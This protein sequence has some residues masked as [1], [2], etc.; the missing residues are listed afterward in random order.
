MALSV[1]RRAGTLRGFSLAIPLILLCRLIIAPLGY[2]SSWQTAGLPFEFYQGS[3]LPIQGIAGEKPQPAASPAYLPVP[4]RGPLSVSAPE[5][6]SRRGVPFPDVASG[7]F[8]PRPACE[9]SPPH[10]H[11]D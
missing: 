6:G 7:R 4:C 11:L 10:P 5:P 2:G 3:P 8:A 1:I 9:R